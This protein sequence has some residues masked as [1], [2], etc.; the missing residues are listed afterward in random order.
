M[1]EI[2]ERKKQLLEIVKPYYYEVH[3]YQEKDYDFLEKDDI[4]I[5]I[6]NPFNTHDVSI[7]LGNDKGIIFFGGCDRKYSGTEADFILL[8]DDLKKILSNEMWLLLLYSSTIERQFIYTEDIET[9]NLKAEKL[10][11]LF[12]GRFNVRR[13]KKDGAVIKTIKWDGEELVIRHFN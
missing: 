11:Y 8:K 10:L 2:S 5:A 4:F 12:N 9:D 3:D 7:Q 6:H 1:I 13:L